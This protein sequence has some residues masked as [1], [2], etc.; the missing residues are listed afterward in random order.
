[1]RQQRNIV[2][3]KEQDKN[4]E[5]LGEMEAGSLLNKDFKVGLPRWS[6]G[7]ESTCQSRG[8]EFNPWSGNQDSTCHAVRPKNNKEEILKYPDTNE[9]K[10]PMIQN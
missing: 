9:N 6:S 1:M 10:G 4:P 5:A 8:H 3:S 2:Q 7:Y